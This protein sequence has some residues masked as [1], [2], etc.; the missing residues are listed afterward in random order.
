MKPALENLNYAANGDLHIIADNS[1]NILIPWHKHDFYEIIYVV[2]NSGKKF[3]GDSIYDFSPNDLSFIGRNLP[4]SY[5]N[6]SIDLTQKKSD[7]PN[8]ILIQFPSNFF[9]ESQLQRV[10]L[11]AVK[12]LL[13]NSERGLTFSMKDSVIAGHLMRQLC[14]AVGMEK[15]L[16]FIKLMD[17]LGNADYTHLASLDYFKEEKDTV[18]I[19]LTKA[20]QYITRYFTGKISLADVAG[21]VNMNPAAFSRYFSQKTGTN[22]SAY[23]T[24]LR[25]NHSCT[26]LKHSKLSIGEIAIES[27]FVNLS[28]YNRYFK[29]LIG[30]SPSQYRS[31]WMNA[32]KE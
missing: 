29:K 25:V 9:S 27:G 8:V 2:K 24:D 3:V 1:T 15:I 7:D 6:N 28:N 30:E 16:L 12:N 17:F 23:L 11:V 21:I 19:R 32:P 26:L 10:E 14:D 18:E 4:H 31:F 5:L 22:F 13:N 20:L